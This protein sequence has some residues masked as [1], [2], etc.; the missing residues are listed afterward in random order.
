MTIVLWRRKLLKH[1]I[2]HPSRDLLLNK[3][4]TVNVKQKHYFKF[5]FIR[6]KIFIISQVFNNHKLLSITSVSMNCL[7]SSWWLECS[8][9]LLLILELFF[10]HELLSPSPKS[11]PVIR[12][13]SSEKIFNEF[14]V[15]KT[16]FLLLLLLSRYLLRLLFLC[17]WLLRFLGL[18]WDFFIFNQLDPIIHWWS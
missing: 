6:N 7:T 14:T 16:K 9:M 2:I 10:L 1:Y 3:T 15:F 17:L 4:H 12:L 13:I 11:N 5:L 18:F 8:F